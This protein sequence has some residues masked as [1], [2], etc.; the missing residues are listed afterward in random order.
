M[1]VFRSQDKGPRTAMFL[2][3]PL[4]KEGSNLL[5]VLELHAE[6]DVVARGARLELRDTP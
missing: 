1:F 6:A 2:A 3:A 4:L 5:Q